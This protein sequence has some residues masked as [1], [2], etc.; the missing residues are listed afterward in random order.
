MLINAC[1]IW[2]SFYELWS[3]TTSYEIVLFLAMDNKRKESRKE[4]KIQ[5]MGMKLNNEE[6][7]VKVLGKNIQHSLYGVYW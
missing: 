2:W 6:Y 7:V 4:S 3:P 5:E 1:H